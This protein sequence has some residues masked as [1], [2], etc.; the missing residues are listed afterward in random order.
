MKNL[1]KIFG[2]GTRVGILKLLL[3]NRGQEYYVRELSKLLGMPTNAIYNASNDLIT[4]GICKHREEKW[5]KFIL[6]EENPEVVEALQV[7]F[8]FLQNED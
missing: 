6:L 5:K 3:E 4:T 8:N 7:L 1:R 2:S